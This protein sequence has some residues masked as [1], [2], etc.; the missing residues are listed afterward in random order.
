MKRT[1]IHT[2]RLVAAP[3][4]L[5]LLQPLWLVFLCANLLPSASLS[6]RLRAAIDLQPTLNEPTLNE[7]KLNELMLNE[8]KLNELKLNG[9]P[10][11]A[12]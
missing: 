4:L 8:L 12:Q 1:A 3:S 7:L 10:T 2:G 6:K 9:V 11:N 5:P